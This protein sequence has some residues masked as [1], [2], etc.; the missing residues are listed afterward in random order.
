MTMTQWQPI[1][2]APKDGSSCYFYTP[3]YGGKQTVSYLYP[4][5]SMGHNHIVQQFTHWH[6]LLP[7]PEPTEQGE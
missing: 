4:D 6:P 2:T 1:D 3:Q 5:G 7:P